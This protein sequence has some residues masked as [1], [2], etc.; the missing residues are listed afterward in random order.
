MEAKPAGSYDIF[1]L[2]DDAL[3]KKLEF[4]QEVPLVHQLYIELFRLLHVP[5][6]V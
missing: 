2:T 1:N 4:I 5:L 3:S 6:S